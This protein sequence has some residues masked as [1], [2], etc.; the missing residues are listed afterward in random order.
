MK[1]FVWKSIFLLTVSL[2]LSEP[3]KRMS[4][5]IS[6]FN[7]FKDTSIL[8]KLFRSFC[9]FS[10]KNG[11][12]RKK[13]S[14][15][16]VSEP[17]SHIGLEAY[18]KLWRNACSFKWLNFNRSLVNNSTPTGS[19]IAKRDLCFTLKNSLNID[20]KCLILL[21]SIGE[22]PSLYHSLTQ[23]GKND[24]LKCSILALNPLILFW[25]DA[26]VL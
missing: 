25:S 11:Q 26:L 16:L 1:L 18:L 10:A 4:D 14:V 19:W 12:R 5:I 6:S 7:F 22:L 23:T 9:L 8:N 15:V 17:Q 21:A 2:Y 13:W 20:L 24:C 3:N